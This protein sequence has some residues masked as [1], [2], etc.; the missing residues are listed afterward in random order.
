MQMSTTKSDAIS[1][2]KCMTPE[3]RVSFPNVFKA[4]AAFEGQEAKFSLVMLF[5]KAIDLGAPTVKGGKS[6]KE[7]VFNAAVEK[8]GPKSEWPEGLKF[9]FKDGDKVKDRAGYKGC[10]YASATSK[11]QPGIVDNNVQPILD[12]KDF[13]AGCVARATVIAYAY[14]R[15]GNKGV[16]LSLQNL[17]KLRDDK[18]FSGRKKAEDEFEVVASSADDPLAYN[19]SDDELGF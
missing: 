11:H 14:D 6:L 19:S 13:Y 7:I 10:M 4:K 15:V 18:P 8:W 12:E 9:P 17:Q 2:K 5:D 3:F 1:S 16:G